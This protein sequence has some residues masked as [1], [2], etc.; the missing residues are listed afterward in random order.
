[1]ILALSRRS[2][3]PPPVTEWRGVPFDL[4]NLWGPGHVS[5]RSP[6]L[7]PE[8]GA[9]SAGEERLGG[10]HR[11]PNRPLAADRDLIARPPKS[12]KIRCRG[13]IADPSTIH[14][15]L[16]TNVSYP[17]S[18][19]PLSVPLARCYVGHLPGALPG[20]VASRF[21]NVVDGGVPWDRTGPRW[22]A[23]MVAPPCTCAYGYGGLTMRPVPFPEWMLEIMAE[24][25]PLCGFPLQ[26][27]WP[28]SCN[29][30]RYDSEWDSVGWHADDEDLFQGWYTDCTIISLSLGQARC[31]SLR[32]WAG[33]WCETHL[34]L[35]GGDLCTME[36]M[37]QRHYK[38]AALKECGRADAAGVRLNL[39]W[40][41]VVAH[42]P[43]C[44][45]AP[46]RESFGI[47]VVTVADGGCSDRGHRQMPSAFL[48]C[49]SGRCRVAV[50]QRRFPSSSLSWSPQRASLPI[51]VAVLGSSASP[52]RSRE[53]GASRG[54]HVPGKLPAQPPAHARPSELPS[55]VGGWADPQVLLT[56][57]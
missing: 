35:A 40:R 52:P 17:L 24:V 41:W 37:T 14:R 26:D 57:V 9:T 48:G 21:F 31:F 56:A 4:G 43:G 54:A 7:T 49:G 8:S 5:T 2:A 45:A 42:T 36:G 20:P 3:L 55:V 53:A 12:V 25:M 1:V 51:A 19:A 50:L 30:N 10:T 13:P 18:K 11:L 32:K 46:Q 29:L 22:T 27:S 28:N 44:P 34:Q 38:H 6:P 16:Q 39:T 33:G 47:A 23:W 15:R